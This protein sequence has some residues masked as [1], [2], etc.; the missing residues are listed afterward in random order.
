MLTRREF[1][2]RLAGAGLF[3]ATGSLFTGCEQR[4]EIPAGRSSSPAGSRTK[5]T[6]GMI[7]KSQSNPV[8]LAARKG[9]QSRAAEL[10]QE[11]PTQVAID[12]QTPN[13][14]DAQKQAEFI[15]QLV[16]GGV[17]AITIAC[18]DA[19]KVSRAID[20][21]IAKGATVMCFDSDAPESKRLCYVGTDDEEAGR[22]V[23]QNVAKL[24]GDK[25]GVVAILAGNETA[26]NL[27]KRVAGARAE[28]GRHSNLTLKEVYYHKETP[29]DSYAAVE[30]A[31]KAHPEITGW[32]M[33]GGWPIMVDK[34]LPWEKGEVTCVSM[35]TLPQ[36]LE[37]LRMGDVQL[38]LGQQYYYFGRQCVDVLFRKVVGGDKPEKTVDFAPLDRVT[39]ENVDEYAKNWDKWS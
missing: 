7:A 38:L 31:Q 4:Q 25:P 30:R 9:A 18:S 12:W 21:A 37:H 17:D 1:N 36:Q 8:F 10:S 16:A 32:A 27:Q 5:L 19:G 26:T 39:K 6:I 3:G 34:P 15:E 13:D 35:D 29:Q 28:L 23:M 20:T 33:I 14:E 11:T 2:Q 22:L 24:L